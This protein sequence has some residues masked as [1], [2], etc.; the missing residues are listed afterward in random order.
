MRVAAELESRP[1]V[2][3]AALMIATA[4]NRDVLLAAGLLTGD[5]VEAG[6]NDLVVAIAAEPAELGPALEEARKLLSGRT[7]VVA[8]GTAE[9][10]APH[11]LREALDEAPDAS[12]VLI[13]TPGTYASAEALKALKAGL[14]VFLFSDNVSVDDEVELKTLA[15][16]KGRLLM[17]PDCGT[18]I[19]GGL[20][21]GF[22]NAVRAGSIGLIGASGTGLQQVACLI[23]ASG[24]GISEAIGVGGGPGNAGDRA[25]IEA[26]SAE[27]RQAGAGGSAR[28]R[29]AGSGQLPRRFGHF[30][31]SQPRACGDAGGCR[32]RGRGARS[33]E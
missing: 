14:D 31:R 17:G 2:Q 33:E 15:R 4:A 23:D 6:P 5:A 10:A 8:H 28:V 1:G 25:G 19:L 3:R 9:R 22:A 11:S 12:L 16:R 20:P 30:R 24:E 21:L 7:R 29:Q 18:A 27:R 26:T 32:H 13:S